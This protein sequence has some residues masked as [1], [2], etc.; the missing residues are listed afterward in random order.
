MEYIYHAADLDLTPLPPPFSSTSTSFL[1]LCYLFLPVPPP[2]PSSVTRF[3]LCHLILCHFLASFPS[4][5]T[6][7]FV[8]FVIVF[9]CF[10]LSSATLFSYSATS[11]FALCHLLFR[12]LL[13]FLVPNYLFFRPLPPLFSSSTVSF[14]VP[15]SLP[16]RPLQPTPYDG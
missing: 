16:P 4:S 13:P 9:C 15:Y 11:F 2:I 10:P 14:F 6:S 7:L 8:F 3:I 5:A 1:T 12:P